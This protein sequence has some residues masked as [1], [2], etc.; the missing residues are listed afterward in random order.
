[1]CV[2]PAFGECILDLGNSGSGIY[3]MKGTAQAVK[4]L[5]EKLTALSRHSNFIV[6]KVLWLLSTG[7]LV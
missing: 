1:V 2:K 6:Q 7:F 3:V 4:K 5:I